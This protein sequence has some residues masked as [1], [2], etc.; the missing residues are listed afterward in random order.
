M[1]MVLGRC[2]GPFGLRR[3]HRLTPAAALDPA[4]PAQ[5]EALMP[6]REGV[7]ALPVC[8]VGWSGFGRVEGFQG[9]GGA[10]DDG[11]EQLGVGRAEV[12]VGGKAAVG[13]DLLGS[14]W[15]EDGVVVGLGGE[16]AVRVLGVGLRPAVGWR[17][18]G[19]SAG[20]GAGGGGGGRRL[21]F[22]RRGGGPGWRL[23]RAS[24]SSVRTI[25]WV[26]ASASAWVCSRLRR[27][28]CTRSS[29]L[30]V[31]LA[32]RSRLAYWAFSL[33]KRSG[34]GRISRWVS[35]AWALAATKLAASSASSALTGSR[36]AIFAMAAWM[37]WWRASSVLFGGIG[38]DGAEGVD[39]LVVHAGGEALAEG[40][41]GG[42]AGPGFGLRRAC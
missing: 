31:E 1:A 39:E 18:G 34:L 17:G 7:L 9:G 32:V 3:G 14:A 24:V 37:R 36:S 25:C 6:V 22:G 11:V 26:Q 38:E 2:G 27:A 35:R 41:G 15:V 33:G 29:R 42:G 16:V 21:G 30:R 4:A 8:G 23:F 20:V 40:L 5:R 10:V 13:A 28:F 12:A 19:G